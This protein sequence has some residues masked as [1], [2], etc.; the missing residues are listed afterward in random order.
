MQR[1]ESTYEI[2]EIT[3]EL[4]SQLHTVLKS[5][6]LSDLKAVMSNFP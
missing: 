4:I 6:G 1:F 5:S 2:V 3:G